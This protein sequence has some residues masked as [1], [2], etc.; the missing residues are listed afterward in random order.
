MPT[1]GPS[2]SLLESVFGGFASVKARGVEEGHRRIGRSYQHRD[3]GAS[4]NHPLSALIDQSLDDPAILHTGSIAHQSHTKFVID[5]FVYD[6]AI[7]F[8]RDEHIEMVLVTEP[9]AIEILFHCKASAEQPNLCE[10]ILVDLLSRWIG[11]VKKGNADSTLNGIRHLVHGVGAQ[12]YEVCA[13]GFKGSCG[14]R[15]HAGGL[16]PRPRT[17]H[18]LDLVKVEAVKHELRGMKASQPFSHRFI[19][20]PV[21][22]NR[23]F[24]AHPAN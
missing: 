13:G 15:E 4:E 20:D 5:D 19:D 24:L 21:V 1:S 11:D 22:R 23:G 14:L 16:V 2:A 18:L 6:P 8:V 12:N 7:R 9:A 17:L 10:S 3:L